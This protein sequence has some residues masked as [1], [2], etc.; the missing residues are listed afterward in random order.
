M[1]VIT[2]PP[3]QRAEFIREGLV[4]GVYNVNK[5]VVLLQTDKIT[6]NGCKIG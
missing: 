5:D 1:A 4:L 6:S 2:F 3:K